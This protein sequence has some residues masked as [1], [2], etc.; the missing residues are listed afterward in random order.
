MIAHG[1]GL[2]PAACGLGGWDLRLA[3]CGLRG[4]A[5]SG[6]RLGKG[7][8]CTEGG[9]ESAGGG[10]GG[11]AA[12]ARVRARAGCVLCVGSWRRGIDRRWCWGGAW[13]CAC[14]EERGGGAAEG[15]GTAVAGGED[16]FEDEDG[17]GACVC[18]GRFGAARAEFAELVD[19]VE[20]AG[21]F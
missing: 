11:A 2:R 10:E 21:G 8:G 4:R 12:V 9:E 5:G 14:F 1:G 20:C 6:V 16:F 19:A 3:A 7:V 18:G 15:V 13:W 17:G